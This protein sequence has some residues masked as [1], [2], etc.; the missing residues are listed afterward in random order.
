MATVSLSRSCIGTAWCDKQNPNTNYSSA[1]SYAL[2]Y[3][4]LDGSAVTSQGLLL[5]KFQA[6]PENLKR[7]KLVSAV[8][9]DY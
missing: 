4:Y 6:F 5:L 1:S 9:T 8:I 7:Q 2:K 3:S